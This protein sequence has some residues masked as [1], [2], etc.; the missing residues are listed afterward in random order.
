MEDLSSLSD[1]LREILSA[2]AQDQESL[3]NVLKKYLDTDDTNAQQAVCEVILEVLHEGDA[4]TQKQRRTLLLEDHALDY[5]ASILQVTHS[6]P[7]TV[8]PLIQLIAIYGK[9]REVLMAF[10]EALQ[11]VVDRAK[12]FEVSDGEETDEEESN[13]NYDELWVEWQMLIMGLT[14]AIPRLPNTRSTPTLLSLQELLSSSIF[15]LGAHASSIW[16]RTAILVLCRLTDTLW[17]WVQTTTDKNGE[18]ASILSNILFEALAIL[19]PKADAELTERWF[20]K[21]FPKY[22]QGPH[23]SRVSQDSEMDRETPQGW[24]QA[25]MVFTQ[26][27]RVVEILNPNKPLSD[28][29]F[30][31]SSRSTYGT[32][33]AFNLLAS[34]I[35]DGKLNGLLPDPLPST[36]LEDLMPVLCAALSGTSVD[37]GIVWLWWIVN[38]SQ[39]GKKGAL[40][41]GYEEV[42]MLLELLVPLTAQHAIPTVRLAL[43]KLM[44]ALVSLQEGRDKVLALRQLLEPENPF[45]SVR[46]ESLSILRQETSNSPEILG[47]GFLAQLNPILFPAPVPN[48]KTCPFSLQPEDLLRN[49]FYASWWTEVAQ[50]V[51]FLSTCDKENATGIRSVYKDVGTRWLSNT[52]GQLDKVEEYVKGLDETTIAEVTGGQGA[53]FLLAKWSDALDRAASAL[54][55]T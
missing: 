36:T 28:R 21:T 17:R 52:R 18:Q 2:P 40:N 15:S 10:S 41:V 45:E 1:S 46:V 20:L 55:S 37:A 22:S 35:P 24:Q 34:T 13:V 39:N 48:D 42:T 3:G 33:A 43:F 6:S 27:L 49:T 53:D 38:E 23:I 8:L 44:G 14:I 50:Y 9:P 30:F 4:Q 25:A 51:W 29:V 47:T 12:G 11:Y 5:T 7:E 16:P 19:G 32:F 26:A 31:S 54:Q